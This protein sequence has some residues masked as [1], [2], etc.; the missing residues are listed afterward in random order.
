MGA[1]QATNRAAELHSVEEPVLHGAQHR[2]VV[3][4]ESGTPRR[5]IARQNGPKAASM[6]KPERNWG[7]LWQ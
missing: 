4:D 2:E 7:T 6:R 3:E 1:A 5:S